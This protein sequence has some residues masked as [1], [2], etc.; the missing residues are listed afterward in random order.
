[1]AAGQKYEFVFAA[2]AGIHIDLT[3]NAD[4]TLTVT[5]T[6]TSPGAGPTFDA[7]IPSPGINSTGPGDG[8]PGTAGAPVG[9]LE[10]APA[11]GKW[12]PYWEHNT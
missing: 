9:W 8:I 2:G 4:G 11:T 1:M 3:P 12:V 10:L 6:N 7:D 5:M